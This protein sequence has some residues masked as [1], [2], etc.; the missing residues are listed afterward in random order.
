MPTDT[1]IDNLVI[2]QLTQA[3]YN[4]ASINN[5]EL[6]F[7]T[8]GKIS[9]D[10]V[11]DSNATN[12]FVTA[13]DKTAWNAKQD[14]LVSGTNIKTVNSTS[15]LGSGNIDVQETLVS[16]T[17]IKTVNSTSL[18]GSGDVTVQETLV[19]GTNIKT[20]N[21]QSL[22]GSG[23]ITISSGGTATDVQINGTSITSNNVADI[24]TETAYNATTNKIATK[25][26]IP[27]DTSDLTNNA[28]YIT[29][30]NSSDVTTALGYTPYSS[31]N[32][33]GYT[34]N[35]GTVTQ[36]NAG[37]GLNTTSDDS[38]IDGG[39]LTSTGT[40]FL[41]KTAVTPGTYQ[42]ITVDKYG[43]VT[44][45]SNQGYTTNTGT[46]TSVQVQAGTGLTSSTSTAQ[47]TTLDTT[48]GID[49]GYK[50]PTTTEWGNKQD[51]LVSGTNIKTINSESILGSGDISTAVVTNDTLS[52]SGTTASPLK[53]SANRL[54]R[55]CCWKNETTIGNGTLFSYNSSTQEE[56]SMLVDTVVFSECQT[57]AMLVYIADGKV[58]RGMVGN[59]T[60]LA[61]AY[62]DWS[63]VI[64]NGVTFTSIKING[65]RNGALYDIGRSSGQTLIDDTKVYTDIVAH[66]NNY[67]T[68]IADGYIY[69]ISGTT[70][71]AQ[72]TTKTF[73]KLFYLTGSNSN[74]MFIID[75]DGYLYQASSNQ[76]GSLSQVG[77]DSGWTMAYSRNDGSSQMG[78][79]ICN[80]VLKNIINNQ[81]YILDNTEVW[82]DCVCTSTVG[83]AITQSGKLYRVSFNSSGA[84]LAQ[85]GTDTDW[86]KTSKELSN[87]PFL[88]IK[89]GYAVSVTDS[90]SPT[91][92][93]LSSQN[94]I[95]KITGGSGSSGT[96]NAYWTGSAVTNI[97]LRYTVNYPQVND[98]TYIDTTGTTGATITAVT[99]NSIDDGT[100]VYQRYTAGD[101][102]FSTIPTELNTQTLT[103]KQLI[104]LLEE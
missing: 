75:S 53:V 94:T 102:T 37:V 22:L 7:V 55:A 15:L 81:D 62:S 82:I 16:G 48:I 19:S 88:L 33:N 63:Y 70:V 3:Q 35:T 90:S 86:Q 13:S 45:A 47:T 2:N 61:T 12:K 5:N 29:G 98:N 104:D 95:T 64:S 36:V 71:T 77:T 32:P 79:G 87:S 58:Y 9:A 17:N 27:T 31:S 100:L 92:T 28:G 97:T 50:L 85:V 30:I 26:D 103:T 44:G 14:E 34:S 69:R 42:G 24:I 18:L 93:T 49:S 91:I 11:D 6:Y 21:N 68:A 8:D 10:D 4:G 41:T 78:I 23:N 99:S 72:D 46:V 52:G 83:L 89:G 84:T 67:I 96:A 57:N 51:T 54:K 39:S 101:S 65:I 80:G 40:L 60:Q 74:Y 1:E 59:Q 76:S 38:D 43:R 73:S 25:A 56:T 20:I 66:R